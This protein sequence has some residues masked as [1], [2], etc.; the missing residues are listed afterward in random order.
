MAKAKE[1]ASTTSTEQDDIFAGLTP[2][3]I[4]EILDLTGQSAN[5]A[6]DKTPVLKVN[7]YPIKDQKGNKVEMGNFVLGQVTKQ[8]GK[9]TIVED[10][11]IDCGPN[12]EITV[13]KFGSKFS[14]FPDVTVVKDAKKHICQS[15]LVLDIGEKAVG[16]NLGFECGPKCPRRGKE[17]KK[18]EK[19]S[20]QYVVFIEIK[21]GDDV[22]KAIMY[23]KGTSFLPFKAYLD[24][25]GKFP[26]FFYPTVLETEQQINGT[27]VYWIVTPVLQKDRPYPTQEKLALMETVKEI[28]SSVREFESNRKLISTQRREDQQKALP[29]GMSVLPP[30]G[31]GSTGSGIGAGAEDADLGD[32]VF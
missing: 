3:Q 1:A 24:S 15:Q 4:K 27:N 28:N 10:I 32:I 9:N 6:F 22:H 21:V 17:V 23:F 8:D 7:K 18:E 14:Y 19:C 20:C 30:E 13:L 5:F 11:G 25:A 31:G 29:P 12:P 16:D 2:E 26:F